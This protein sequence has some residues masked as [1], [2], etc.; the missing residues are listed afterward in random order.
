MKKTFLLIAFL[1]FNI[2]SFA[3]SADEKAVADAVEKIRV[4]IIGAKEADLMKL[5]SPKLTY[6][7]SNGLM[8]DQAAFI[9][10]LVSEESKFTK[11]D[12]SE[13]TITVSGDVAMVRHKLIGDTHNKGKDPAPVRLGVF[14]VWQKVKGQWILIGRQAFKLV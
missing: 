9:R 5:T 11:I 4:A 12:L 6:G 3:Q 10:A 1:L 2:A 13:Q 8:E 14:M 7:H